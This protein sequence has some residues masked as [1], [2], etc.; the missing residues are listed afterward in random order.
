MEIFVFY[1]LIINALGFIIMSIDK[2]RARKNLWRIPERT[3]FAF[4]FLGG[5]FGV[6]MGIRLLRHKTR[7]PAFFVGIPVLFVIQV[8][9]LIFS[10]ILTNNV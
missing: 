5:S 10:I 4:A 6:L 2:R 7:K 3:L 1:L 8:V 9:L